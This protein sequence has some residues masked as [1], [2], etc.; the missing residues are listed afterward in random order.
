M[1]E[2]KPSVLVGVTM[3]RLTKLQEEF[4][5]QNYNTKQYTSERFIFFEILYLM[6]KARK[7]ILS[8]K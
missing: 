3:C 8:Q 2:Q 4:I 5:L 1:E 7:P 6:R